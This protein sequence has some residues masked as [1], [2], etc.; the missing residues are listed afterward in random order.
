MSENKSELV[1]SFVD[2]YFN[3]DFDNNDDK[4]CDNNGND[5]QS[6]EALFDQILEQISQQSAGQ[7]ESN[8]MSETWHNYHLIGDVLRDELP[9]DLPLDLSAEIAAK[10]ANE[11]TVLSPSVDSSP[12]QTR[13]DKIKSNIVQFIKPFGQM[14]IAASAAGLMILGVQNNVADTETIIPSQV[15]QTV[16]FAGTANPVSF[17]YQSNDRVSKKQAYLAQQRRFQALLFDHQQQLKFNNNLNTS[18]ADVSATQPLTQS[19]TQSATQSVIPLKQVE[20]LPK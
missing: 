11:P 16:P 19:A 13:A 14:A 4:S 6:N 5:S 9:A 2:N 8:P 7:N 17:N 1:S 20:D 15:V 12:E 18:T 3:D 10:I